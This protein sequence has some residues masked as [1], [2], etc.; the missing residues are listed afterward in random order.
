MDAYACHWG[1]GPLRQPQQQL[2]RRALP[3]CCC[4]ARPLRRSRLLPALQVGAAPPRDGELV[5]LD[6]INLALTPSEA[7]LAADI[8]EEEEEEH[9]LGG[10]GG[11]GAAPASIALSQD[12]AAP[13]LLYAVHCGGAH[14]VSLSW[15]PLL[16]VLLGEEGGGGQLPPALPRPAVEALLHSGR[17]LVA[18]APVGDA[19]SGSA[20]VVLEANGRPRCLRPHRATLAGAAAPASTP[21]GQLVAAGG[22]AAAQRD[23]D[24]QI[25][26]TYGDLRT[27]E[28]GTWQR[29][30]L[31]G[32]CPLAGK[33]WR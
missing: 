26:T 23:V 32:Y 21:G 30:G 33:G 8:E 3:A 9:G 5:L 6:A 13:E 17:G 2:P 25:A 16:A 18:A 29:E 4:P 20:L 12:A 15:L 24:S 14:A 19:L 1:S 10:G 28:A 11:G 27:G 31:G 22:A 7:G